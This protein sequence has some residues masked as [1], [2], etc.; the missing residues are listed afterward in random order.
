MSYPRGTVTGMTTQ[1]S[2]IS[3]TIMDQPGAGRVAAAITLDGIDSRITLRDLIRT[4]VR[5][6]VARYNAASAR[7]DVFRGLVMPD[8]AEPVPGGFRMPKPR[9]VDWEQQAGQALESF[10]RNGFFVL[11]A[12]RQVTELDEA[13]ELTADTDIRFIRLVQLVGG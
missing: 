1:A 11:V 9:R 13:L 6:E 3:V 5:E 4:R 12:D 10:R 8:G 2:P 7:T